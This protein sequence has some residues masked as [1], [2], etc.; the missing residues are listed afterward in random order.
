MTGRLAQ[1]ASLI[2]GNAPAEGAFQVALESMEGSTG[3]LIP[4]SETQYELG[5]PFH[6]GDVLFG[7]LRP[8]LAKVWLADRPGF[9]IGDI[10]VYRPRGPVEPRYLRYVILDREFI[11]RVDAGTY[12]AKMPRADW[13]DVK[14]IAVYFPDWDK[15]QAIADFLDRETAQIDAMI[16]AQKDLIARLG[17][18]RREV[19]ARVLGAGS[20]SALYTRSKSRADGWTPDKIR[21]R[22]TVTLGKMLDAGRDAFDDDESTPYL[23]AANIQ[24]GGLELD[25]VRHMPFRPRELARLD[26]RAGDLLVVEGGAIGTNVILEDDMPGWSF[27]KTVNR[28]RSINGDSTRFVGHVLT[29]MRDSGFLDVLCNRSTIPHFT[30]EKLRALQVAFPQIPEQHRVVN[31]IEEAKERVDAMAHAAS[32]VITLLS[33]RREALI[34][35][36]VTGRIDPKTGIEHIDMTKAMVGA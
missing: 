14:N 34:T 1:Y 28:V 25:D 5:T 23:R 36:A 3:R 8:Y 10:H 6:A 7:K 35:A 9:A 12:G 22:F 21:N 19:I 18:R 32:H 26:L 27:Q 24:D 31:E 30:A 17:E 20:P 15:Q 2:S 13:G 29:T 33:E 16:E 11:R 4:D